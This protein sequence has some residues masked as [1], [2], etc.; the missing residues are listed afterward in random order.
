[1]AGRIPSAGRDY[2]NMKTKT[3]SVRIAGIAAAIP[4]RAVSYLETAASAGVPQAEAEEILRMTGVRTRHVASPALCTSDLAFAAAERLIAELGWDRSTIDALLV[5][6]QTPDYH[7]PATACCLQDRLGLPDTCAAFDVGLGCS[8]YVYGLWMASTLIAAGGV[9]RV[10]L[11]AGDTI[12]RI[13]APMDRSTVF[14]FGDAGTATALE[15][16]EQSPP[17]QFLLGSDGSGEEFLIQPSGGYRTPV[18]TGATVQTNG[19]GCPREPR[20]LHMYGSEVFAFTLRRVPPLIR[21]MLADAG[22]GIEHVDAVVPHQANA[23]M[24]EHLRKRMKIP[25]EK[26][27][28]S[29]DRFGNTSSASIPLAISTCLAERVRV[30][31]LRILLAGFGV[32]WS[33][34]AAAIV[35][36]PAIMPDVIYVREKPESSDDCG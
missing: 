1:V 31:S 34:G 21:E 33:W 18:D 5:V 15:R 9:K 16:N 13:C 23:F 8:G 30:G 28:V 29:L 14:L 19:T 24:L 22:W 35:C 6:T 7:L 17:M 12:S 26:M 27:V 4:Q 25:E 36:G 2:E 32:G 3:D 10:L 11:I 20:H